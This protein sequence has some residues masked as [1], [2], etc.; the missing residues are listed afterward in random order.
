M[1]AV[2][3]YWSDFIASVYQDLR[4]R[5]NQSVD[6][7]FMSQEAMEITLLEFLTIIPE[8]LGRVEIEPV[9]K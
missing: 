6:G 2:P 5:V 9:R 7:I 1:R 3:T 4:T 8:E